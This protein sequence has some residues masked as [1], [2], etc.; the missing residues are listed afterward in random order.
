MFFFPPKGGWWVLLL[1]F[2]LT[3]TMFADKKKG[4]QIEQIYVIPEP[5]ALPKAPLPERSAPRVEELRA[6]IRHT[7]AGGQGIDVSHYQGRIDWEEVATDKTISFVYIKATEG[8]NLVD[9][10][11]LRNLYGAKRVGIPAGAYHFFS[12][13]VSALVQLEN[14]RSVVDPRQQDLIPVVDVEKRGKASLVQF[15]RSLKAFLDGVE[16]M[17]GVKPIIYTGV[18]FYAKYLE[19]KFTGYKFM[20]A[21]YADEF[22]GLSEDVPIVM[23]QFTQTGYADGIGGHVDKSVFLDRYGLAD[24][25]LP[26]SVRGKK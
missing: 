13:S 10:F 9:E 6:I 15:Q 1:C 20:V 23:W 14:F 25:M 26:S 11:Y 7:V 22:P 12:P 8:A 5:D 4:K 16:H 18:N 2:V 24:I 3:T 17:F 21:R 19:G